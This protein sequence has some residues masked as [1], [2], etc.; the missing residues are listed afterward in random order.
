MAS[1]VMRSRL[2]TAFETDLTDTH[3]DRLT[4]LAGIHDL[5]KFSKVFRTSS[6]KRLSQAVGML[7]RPSQF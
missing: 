3:L 4:V 1:P 2:A 5:G 6:K 7:L